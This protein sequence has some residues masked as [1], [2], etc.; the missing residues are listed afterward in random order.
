MKE[1]MKEIIADF[2]GKDVSEIKEDMTFTD[3]GID[4]LDIAELVMQIEDEFDVSIEMSQEINTI[5][6]LADYI[7]ANK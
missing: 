4:S 3:M 2:L 1:K 7:E 5:N 6:A